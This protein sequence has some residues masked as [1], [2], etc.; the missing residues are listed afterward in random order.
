MRRK[1]NLARIVAALVALVLVLGS[2]SDRA[3]AQEER[4]D[5]PQVRAT[6]WA[7]VDGDTGLY[8]AGKNPDRRLPVASTTKIMVALLALEEGANLEEEV[9]ISGQA[10]RF[11]GTV[12]SNIGLIE[13]ERLSVRELLKAALIPSGTEAV[14]ALS[15]HLGGGSVGVFVEDMNQE[16]DSMGL[17]NTHFEN[18]AGLDARGHYS[19]ARDLATMARAAMEYPTFADMVDTERTRISTQNREIEFS[20][21]NNLLYAYEQANGVKTGTSPQ[22][23][24]CLV[25]SATEGDESYLA[26]VLDAAGEEYRFDAART[27]LEYGFDNYERE[28]LARKGEVYEEI[29][30]PFRREESVG[31]VAARDVPGPAGPGLEVER[32]VTAREAPPA[33]KAGQELG[34]VE[35]LVSGE[36]VGTSPLVTKRGYEEASLWQKVRYWSSGLAMRV[37]RWISDLI[38]S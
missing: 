11:V 5:P 7:L 18:P 27:A 32:R 16:A 6:A 34:T 15:E 33:A 35:V 30:P 19:S 31:L 9:A 13:G 17:K 12:Y 3:A 20:N 1:A 36:R 26:V 29:Q 22:A 2:G 38:P 37:S 4:P 14:Y 21:T 28:P 24:P 25:A 23:G 8:L 10:E